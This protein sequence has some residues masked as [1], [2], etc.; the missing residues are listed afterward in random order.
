MLSMKGRILVTLRAD[1]G[2][3]HIEAAT[4]I[5]GQ[6]YDW[7]RSKRMLAKLFGD[8]DARTAMFRERDL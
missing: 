7:G 6:I 2:R 4:K 5:P 8:V 1:G 3:V